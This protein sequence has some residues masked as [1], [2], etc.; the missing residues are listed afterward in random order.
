MKQQ[1]GGAGRAL[2]GVGLAGAAL[3][4]AVGLAACTGP[5]VTSSPTGVT[6]SSSDGSITVG[7]TMPPDWPANVPT[8]T[9]VVL[10]N[11]GSVN[12]PG[13]KTITL[14]YQGEATPDAV[15]A[16]LD[17]AFKAAEFTKGASFG[18]SSGG[19]TVWEQGNVKVQV[20][21]SV[22]DGQTVVSESAVIESAGSSPN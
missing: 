21:I 19:V 4:L 7:A 1:L 17:Q 6:I 22:Q 10:K 15:S 9:G 13:V 16:Q 18:G 3:G 8:P 11:A 20:T 2:A 5:S 12:S 14:V